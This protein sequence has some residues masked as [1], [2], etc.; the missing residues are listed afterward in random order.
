MRHAIIVAI[1][2][3][4]L[5]ALALS[6]RESG[7][8][9]SLFAEA[10]ALLRQAGAEEDLRRKSVM[11]QDARKRLLRVVL[12]YGDSE[13]A[14][15][16]AG[17]GVP[18]VGGDP[19][20]LAGVDA[21]LRRL[22]M[23]APTESCVMEE[24]RRIEGSSRPADFED[25]LAAWPDSTM[26]PEARAR[27]AEL[28]DPPPPPSARKPEVQPRDPLAELP[29]PRRKPRPPRPQVAETPPTPPPVQART[30]I[31]A[32]RSQVRRNWSVPT[33]AE[34]AHEMNV[35]LD[36][37]LGPDG[38][39]RDVKVVE[40]ARMAQDAA[41]RAMAESAV[42]AVRKT[43]RFDGLPP[44]DYARWRDIRITFNP[45]DMFGA[46]R[47]SGGAQAGAAATA[48]Y[49]E[50]LHARLNRAAQ[51]SYPTRSINRG[52]EGVVPVLLTIGRDGKLLQV[53]VLDDTLAADR[54][55]GAAIRAIQNSAPF[56]QFAADMG[57]EPIEITIRLG[58]SLR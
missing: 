9:Q 7:S 2:V 3:A 45:E 46:L 58:Y 11:L 52:E 16:I 41:F 51:R 29:P 26:A 15:R 1:G 27:L 49:T 38:A 6:A 37:R 14:V 35:T 44:E 40:A 32:I 20:T 13:I 55:V 31:D 50:G 4:L 19:I 48:A 18:V 5:P 30:V 47:R 36:L 24:W 42:R 57:G 33:G 21:R 54:L 34:D 25:F 8:A 10:V 23:A 39:V 22:C 12:E 17:R 43:A 53:R 28:I 56:P